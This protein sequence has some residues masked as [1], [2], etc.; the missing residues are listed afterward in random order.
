MAIPPRLHFCWIGSR[1]PWAYAFAPL[2]AA[3]RSGMQDIIL[4]HT[5]ELDEGPVLRALRGTRGLRLHRLSP[6]ACLVPVQQSLGLGP[7]LTDLYASL[8]SPVQRSDLLRAAILHAEGGV[9]L[10]LDTVTVA[11]LTPLLSARQFIGTEQ[12]VWPLWI[13]GARAPLVWA[14]HLGLDILRKT[15]RVAPGGWRA[16]RRVQGWYVTAANNAVMGGEPAAPLFADALRAMAMLPADRLPGPY[17]L[18]PDLYQSLLR[19][20]GYPGLV[21]HPAALFYPLPPEISEHWFR[22]CRRAGSALAE[23]LSPETAVVHWYGSVRTRALV[24]A[25]SPDS[26]QALAGRQLYSA[27]VKSA[28]A[29]LP[30]GGR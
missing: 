26:V 13:Y 24:E 20:R 16:F 19:T 22:P 28:L 9:Y 25:I 29:E 30:P 2:S 7:A 12:I 1:L 10:D 17:A 27:L 11:P 23:V 8:T 21:V 18:G 5:D 4:H 6:E 15:L 3:A 14:K